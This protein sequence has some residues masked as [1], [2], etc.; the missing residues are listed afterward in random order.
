MRSLPILSPI[1]DHTLGVSN[2]EEKNM[3]RQFRRNAPVHYTNW[4]VDKVLNWKNA[5][6][7]APIFHI[8]G[9]QDRIFSI[10]KIKPTFKVSGGGHLMI[11]NKAEEVSGLINTIL[12]QA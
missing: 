4:A 8:H 10:K 11:M 1:T 6:C 7:P 5:A 9:D 3:V 2:A 12:E